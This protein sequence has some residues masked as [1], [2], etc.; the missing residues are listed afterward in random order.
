MSDPVVIVSAIIKALPLL[1]DILEA[2]EMWSND[3]EI[4]PELLLRLQATGQEEADALNELRES[5]REE[6]QE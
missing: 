4:S 2:V 5:L 1:K 6:Q 3:E